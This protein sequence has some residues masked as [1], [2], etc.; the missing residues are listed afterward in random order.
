[1]KVQE[2]KH[3]LD[4]WKLRKEFS[5]STGKIRYDIEG[6]GPPLVLVHGTPWSSYNWRHIIPALANWWTVYYYDLLGY[7]QSGKYP[8]RN[9]SRG[10]SVTTPLG[11]WAGQASGLVLL[12]H[13][14]QHCRLRS[15]NPAGFVFAV[16]KY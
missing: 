1:M 14:W 11:C 2:M 4:D 15:D 8:D 13:N 16:S 12:V 9:R 5:Y 6:D 7:G 3:K 10:K